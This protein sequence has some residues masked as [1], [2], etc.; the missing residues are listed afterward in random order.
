MKTS[1]CLFA[2]PLGGAAFVAEVSAGRGNALWE[3]ERPRRLGT[4]RFFAVGLPTI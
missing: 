3:K 4:A 2:T 1:G